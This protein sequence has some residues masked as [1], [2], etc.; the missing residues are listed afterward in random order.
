MGSA[1]LTM[2]VSGGMSSAKPAFPT[3]SATAGNELCQNTDYGFAPDTP[4]LTGVAN[5]TTYDPATGFVR[6]PIPSYMHVPVSP[7]L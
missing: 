7:A 4:P 3:N 1:K 5:P 6:V 2:P